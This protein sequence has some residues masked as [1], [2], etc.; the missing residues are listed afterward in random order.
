ML[1]ARALNLSRDG[2]LLKSKSAMCSTD[3]VMEYNSLIYTRQQDVP[4]AYILG[5][6]EFWSLPFAVDKHTLIPRPESELLVELAVEHLEHLSPKDLINVLDLGT[7]SGCLLL[8]LLNTAPSIFAGIGVDISYEALRVA[9]RNAKDLNLEHRAHFVVSN[10]LDGINGNHRYEVIVCNPPYVTNNEWLTLSDQVKNYEPKNALTDHAD[11][12]TYYRELAHKLG[13]ALTQT[14]I[15]IL[16]CGHT[17]AEEVA[18]IMD[19]GGR[20]TLRFVKDLAGIDRALI[21]R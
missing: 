17:Q 9:K 13:P 11:G 4:I 8:A 18:R 10:W 21:I 5:Q 7:G 19:D 6:Q 12:L 20:A 16:E 14:G 1:L 3:V 2:L 15:A